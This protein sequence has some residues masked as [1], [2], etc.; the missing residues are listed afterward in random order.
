MRA[1]SVFPNG[2]N[3]NICNI[4][5]DGG[6]QVGCGCHSDLRGTFGVG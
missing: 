2:A 1:H 3:G 5:P 4:G 6:F